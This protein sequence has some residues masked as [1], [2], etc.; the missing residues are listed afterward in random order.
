[1]SE[2]IVTKSTLNSTQAINPD[3]H[4]P[5]GN[6]K[7]FCRL[8][9][10]YLINIGP[11]YPILLIIAFLFTGLGSYMISFT[12]NHVPLW[13]WKLYIIIFTIV[14]CLHILMFISDPGI[15]R[16]K[17]IKQDEE[18]GVEGDGSIDCKKCGI[19]K[20]TNKTRHCISCD[21]CIEGFD[22]H[23]IFLGKCIGK[24]NLVLFYLYVGS[25][26]IFFWA[27][28]IMCGV[29]IHDLSKR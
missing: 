8:K 25:I 5:H 28:I 2:S 22:H 18:K 11:E 24:R 1:M 7:R 14:V 6:F 15:I 26:P 13:S 29:T 20:F 21:V 27:T 23:C 3:L 19:I 17:I 16:K 10:T 4:S 9:N 12:Q